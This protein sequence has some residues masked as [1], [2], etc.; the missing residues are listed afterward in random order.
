MPS[1]YQKELQT[2][3]GKASHFLEFIRQTIRFLPNLLR[4]ESDLFVLGA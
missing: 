1:S 2:I 3:S 4:K